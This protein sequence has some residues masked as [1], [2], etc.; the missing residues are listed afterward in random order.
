MQAILLPLAF[1][2]EIAL[3]LAFFQ[4]SEIHSTSAIQSWNHWRQGPA[5]E[6]E[7]AWRDQRARLRSSGAVIDGLLLGFLGPNTIGVFVLS[8]RLIKGV[9]T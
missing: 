3:G 4:H 5:P 7:E 8:K 1:A 6:T 9:Q 2:T